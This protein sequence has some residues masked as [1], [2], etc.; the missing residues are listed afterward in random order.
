MDNECYPS[1]FQW[2]DPSKIWINE[3]YCLLDHW[4]QQKESRLV[5][6]LWNP[7]CDILADV[8]KPYKP[9]QNAE[10][11]QTNGGSNGGSDED[12]SNEL[13]AIHEQDEEFQHSPPLSLSPTAAERTAHRMELSRHRYIS[14]TAQSPVL[15]HACESASLFLHCNIDKYNIQPLS[16]TLA[17]SHPVNHKHSTPKYL[18]GLT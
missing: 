4:R 5:P 15:D 3:A 11:L 7:S 12:F 10:H 18:V 2:A 14:P 16:G 8:E 13:G 17:S 1:E 6:I 9:H